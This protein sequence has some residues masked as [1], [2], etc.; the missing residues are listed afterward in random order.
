[1]SIYVTTRNNLI[2]NGVEQTKAGRT[3]LLDRK[4]FLYFVNIER[5]LRPAD[6]ELIQKCIVE[7]QIYLNVINKPQLIMFAYRYI[8]HHGI[9]HKGVEQKEL[10]NGWFSYGMVYSHKPTKD[11]RAIYTWITYLYDRYHRHY[12]RSIYGESTQVKDP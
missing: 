8:I 6:F 2:K 3:I 4:L 9:H 7:M 5:A 1:M 12:E 11:E 10:E